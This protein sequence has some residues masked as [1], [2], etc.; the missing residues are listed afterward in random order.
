MYNIPKD[1]S[2]SAPLCIFPSLKQAPER[3]GTHLNDMEI[4]CFLSIARTGSFTI[5]ARELSSTQQAVS[6]NIQSLEEELGFPLLNR[7]SQTITLTWAGERFMNWRM[8]HDAQ[9]SALELQSRRMSPQGA[10]ELYVAWNDWT[11]CPEGFEEDI[12]GFC[13]TYPNVRLHTRQGSTEEVADMLK[14][15]HADIAVLPEYST[16]NLGGLIVSS[17]FASQPLYIITRDA[18]DVPSADA[19]ATVTQLAAPMGEK[20]EEDILRRIHMFCAEA[21][22]APKQIEVMP[23]V[24]SAYSQLLCGNCYTIG[25]DADIVRD[26]PKRELPGPG[27]QLVF[28]TAQGRVG[29]WTSLFES[30]VR[31]RR[32]GA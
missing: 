2:F 16:H 7:G 13:Q 8:E 25:P 20:S 9:L 26:L 14:N 23:N 11:G 27:I 12:R 5:S 32:S 29:P 1:G 31:Q 10:D 28:V 21:G 6:R 17:P 19:L 24:R 4:A 30:F 22:I 3:E 15:G 18:A